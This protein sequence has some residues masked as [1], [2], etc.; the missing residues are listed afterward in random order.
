MENSK[1]KNMSFPQVF[2]GNLP[3]SELLLKKEKQP[4]FMQKVEDPQQKLLGMTPNFTSGLHPTYNYRAIVG[5]TPDLY[6]K[7]RGFTLIELLVVVLIIGILAA[8]ALPKYQVAVMKTHY[9]TL[10]NMA[11]KM[12]EAQETYH[13]ANGTYAADFDELSIDIGGS[14]YGAGTHDAQKFPW[15][16]CNIAPSYC[17]CSYQDKMFFRIFYSDGSQRC[18]VRPNLVIETQVCKQETGLNAPSYPA[19]P[20]EAWYDY[21]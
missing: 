3:L 14:Y 16:H 5:L 2:G 10:K 12:A 8:V 1:Y 19:S 21:Q 4:C 13:L 7:Q 20:T 6:A 18:G 9:A 15:G 17:Q 11:K